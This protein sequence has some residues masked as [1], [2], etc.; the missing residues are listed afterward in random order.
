M[1]GSILES[2][3]GSLL[4]RAEVKERVDWLEDRLLFDLQRAA[5]RPEVVDYAL[6]EFQRQ[7]TEALSNLTGQIGRMRQRREEI[8]R[9]LRNLV[10]TAATVGHS[11]SLVEAINARETE[12]GEITQRLFASQPDSVSSEIARIR[13]FVS[14]RLGN[15]R[16][17][18]SG[19]VEGA[20]LELAKHVTDI[21]LNPEGEGKKAHYVAAGEWNLLG[22]YSQG[23]GGAEMRV[24][25]VAGEGFEPSTFGL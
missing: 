2:R 1:P 25:M 3:G 6:Q 19:D 23:E 24:R 22:G 10:E 8:Q 5:L 18:L 4:P 14:E 21:R 12:L 20:K 16:E 9:Q 13:Q 15:I 17:L 11:P 7:L